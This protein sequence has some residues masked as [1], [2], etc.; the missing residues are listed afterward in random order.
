MRD[1]L[2]VFMPG[3]SRQQLA[4]ALNTAYADGLLSQNTLAHRLDLLFG[5]RLIDPAGLVGDLARRVPRRAWYE[6]IADTIIAVARSINLRANAPSAPRPKLLALDWEG[7]QDELVLG[8]EA[9]CDVVLSDPCVS[10]R[11]ARLLFR[12][13][14]WVIQDLRSTNG[15]TV[16]D[17]RVGRCQ[18]RAG[19]RIRLGDERLTID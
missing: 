19:D 12:D 7:G 18:L 13:G 10:R 14:N 2:V 3:S 15:T 9:S 8:R 5:S 4:R 11:H 16:N 17:V 6:T 1:T